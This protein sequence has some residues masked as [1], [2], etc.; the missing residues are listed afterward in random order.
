M[1]Q[2]SVRPIEGETRFGPRRQGKRGMLYIVSGDGART[3]RASDSGRGSVLALDAVASTG[4]ITTVYL[5]ASSD[6]KLRT[7][8]TY[9]TDTESG[10]VIGTQT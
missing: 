2:R 1:A 4:V 6:G 5:W 9:P 8:T 10:T 3:A 7:G